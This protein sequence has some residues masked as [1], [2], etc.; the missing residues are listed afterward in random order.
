[1]RRHA[2]LRDARRAAMSIAWPS[3]NCKRGADSLRLTHAQATA[4]VKLNHDVG[5][6]WRPP[7]AFALPLNSQDFGTSRWQLIIEL[8]TFPGPPKGHAMPAYGPRRRC[9]PPAVASGFW[10]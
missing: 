5:N 2:A 1:M 8:Y 4:V 10:G 9:R 7:W 3:L 6:R